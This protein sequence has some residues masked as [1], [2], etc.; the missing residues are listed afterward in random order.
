MIIAKGNRI[1]YEGDFSKLLVETALI[2]A[3]LQDL[4]EQAAV[5]GEDVG[6]MI[7]ETVAFALCSEEEKEEVLKVKFDEIERS[8][9]NE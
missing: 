4:G 7:L 9:D 3:G 8:L 2:C 6:T 1:K 5:E